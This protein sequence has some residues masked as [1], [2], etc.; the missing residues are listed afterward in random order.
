M[1]QNIKKI[2]LAVCVITLFYGCKKAD[3]EVKIIG[4]KWKTTTVVTS[5]NEFIYI[6]F[7]D[8]VTFKYCYVDYD[9]NRLSDIKESS[10]IRTNASVLEFSANDI[11]LQSANLGRTA[12]KTKPSGVKT[13]GKP[14]MTLRLDAQWVLCEKV[15]KNVKGSDFFDERYLW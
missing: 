15:N 11:S 12:I 4:T 14:T 3:K 10:Y 5:S 8:N 9:L 1:K 6:H 13:G 7:I 2:V